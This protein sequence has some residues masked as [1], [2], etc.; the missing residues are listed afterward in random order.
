MKQDIRINLNY[1]Y[2]K[3]VPLYNVSS[4]EKE[5]IVNRNMKKMLDNDNFASDDEHEENNVPNYDILN[6][7]VFDIYQQVEA[8]EFAYSI[9]VSKWVILAHQYPIIDGFLK[10]RKK[11]FKNDYVE[12]TLKISMKIIFSMIKKKKKY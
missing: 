3:I 5:N 1:K 4:N 11:W 9:V 10:W 8:I 2:S 6:K 12:K 7:H